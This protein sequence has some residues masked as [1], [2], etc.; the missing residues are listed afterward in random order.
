MSGDELYYVCEPW[1]GPRPARF[2]LCDLIRINLGWRPSILR[3]FN[4]WFA[5]TALAH[6]LIKKLYSIDDVFRP[7]PGVNISDG[8]RRCWKCEFAIRQLTPSTGRD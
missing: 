8:L 6:G 1:I 4:R 5:A 2:D 7:D 3:D